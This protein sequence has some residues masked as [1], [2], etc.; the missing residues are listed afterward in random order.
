MSQTDRLLTTDQIDT[1]PRV[2]NIFRMAL[3]LFGATVI[4]DLFHFYLAFQLRTWQMFALAWVTFAFGIIMIFS[5]GA[6]RRGRSNLGVGLMIGGMLVVIPMASALIADLGVVLALSLILLTSTIAAQMSPPKWT[7]RA[8]IASVVVGVA[9]LLIDLFGPAYRLVV[10]ELQAFLPAMAGLLVVIYAFFVARQFANYSL[11]TKL[12]L[13]FLLVALIP[14]GILGFSNIRATRKELADV[15]NQSLT[16]AASQTAAKL[17]TFIN[18][19]LDAIRTEAQT[20]A[21]ARYLSQSASRRSG[22]PEEAEVAAILQA[23]AR[24][25]Q[26][27]ILSYALLDGRGVNALDTHTPDIGLN[28]A[29]Q[30]YFQEPVRTGL[31]YVSPVQF[32]PTR[33]GVAE[34]Y[35]S[36]P[37][38]NSTGNT[39]GV[40]RVRYSATVLQQFIAQSRGL[41]GEGSVAILLDENHIRLADAFKPELVF[42]SVVPLDPTEV[43]ELKVK[44][45]L[46]DLSLAELATNLPD[47]EQVLNDATAEQP[48]F[49]STVYPG[50]ASEQGAVVKLKTRDWSVAVVQ[51]ESVL[52]APVKAQTRDSLLLALVIAGVVAAVAVGVGQLLIGPLARLTDTAA[53]VSAGD[54]TA[55]AQVEAQ[56]EVG[57]LAAAF[58]AMTGR[59][60]SMIDTLAER[61]SERTQQLQTVVD[62]SQ[63][64]TAILDLSDLLHQ[65]VTVTKETFNYYHVHIYLLDDEGENLVVAEGYGQAGAE[66][67]RQA[68]SISFNAPQSLVARAARERKVITVENVRDDPNWLSNPLLPDTQAEMAVPVMIG[69]DVVGVLDVQSDRIGGL[70]TEDEAIQQALANQVA[71]AVRNARAFSRTQE[72]L[73][74]AQRLQRLYIRQSWEKLTRSQPATDYE[75]RGSSLP[76]LQEIT[77]PEALAA[78]QQGQTIELNWPSATGETANGDGAANLPPLDDILQEADIHALATPLKLRD[79]VIGVLGIHD[80]NPDRRWTEDEIALIE[81]VSE[82]MSLALE[83]ARLFEETQHRAAREEV[84]ARLTQAVWGGDDIQAVLSNAVANLGETLQASRVVLRLG[85]EQKFVGQEN[86]R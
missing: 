52:L 66:L 46:P 7:S 72:A 21:L 76:P 49:I 8:I 59:L 70:T 31:P 58:N 35:F 36:S 67:K 39:I 10:P 20:P 83:S 77:T 82:Q 34:L 24:K 68:H 71:V 3:I 81:A 26:L 74:E 15:A 43:T 84:I 23:L 51:P 18:T 63:R 50:V 14:L 16:A 79:Q 27:Y 17:D 54:L 56:D 11:R 65:V 53:R 42:K 29:G 41:A 69:D 61:V 4:V 30:D 28:V 47:F 2:H 12:I 57:A 37:V 80:Q 85:T 25:D 60:R 38:R 22:S 45:R 13:A 33:P 48:N 6:I 19:N 1:A 75:F 9:T 40:L 32:S 78:L 44:G 55:Q 62:I 5:L 86:D 64:L 73:Y